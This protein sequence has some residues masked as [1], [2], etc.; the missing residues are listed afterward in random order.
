M[1]EL[2]RSNHQPA[3]AI[4]FVGLGGAG[5][6]VLDRLILDGL[7]PDSAIAMNTDVQA[8]NGSVTRMKIH[9]GQNT[10]RGLGTGGDPDLGH[11]AAEEAAEEISAALAGGDMVFVCA[12]LG[13]GTGGGAAPLIAHLARKAGAFTVVFATL[14][15]AF[16]GR[17][18][19]SQAA[20]ALAQIETQADLV[21]CFENDRMGEALASAG[22]IQQ[23]FIAA[24]Q[25]LSQ[26]IRAVAA[27]V[28]RPGLLALGLDDLSA[29]LKKRNTRCLFGYGESDGP[30]RA[31]EALDRALRSPLMDRGR[32]LAGAQD[33]LIHITG[34]PDLTLNE[35]TIL[36]EEFN[37]HVSDHTRIHFGFATDPHLARRICVA[38]LS[39]EEAPAPVAK[40]LPQAARHVETPAPA[41]EPTAKPQAE[42]FSA[43]LEQ[44]PSGQAGAPDEDD[45]GDSYYNSPPPSTA[46]PMPEHKAVPKYAPQ[47]ATAKKEERAEQMPLE[48]ASRGRFEKSE[49]TIV[50]GEDLDV[51]TFLRK[52]T[53]VK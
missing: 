45:P 39:A 10:T 23:A 27:I 51:P 34:G 29:L 15:F 25:T 40:K 32:M 47:P 49:P 24:D 36:M 35:A 21:V 33:V 22:G 43:P 48:P 12:G 1:I 13:G 20:E 6:N 28:Q 18:R 37:R 16:E 2:P 8:L 3:P 52:N 53:R 7:D 42:L 11:A 17:R 5:A 14:P 26:G 30:N 41:A 9:L 4:K 38:I 44:E 50:D 31:H 46:P 19:T